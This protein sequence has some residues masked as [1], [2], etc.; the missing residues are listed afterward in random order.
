MNELIN[1]DKPADNKAQDRFQRYEFSKR[2][3][4]IISIPKNDKSLIV[5]LYGKWG[6]GKSTIL[7]FIQ[8]ELPADTVI[9]NFNPWL[10]SDEKHLLNSFFASFAVA[11]KKSEKSGKEKI[12]SFLSD[13]ADAIG[14]ITQFVGASTDGLG[15]L[16]DKLKS[17]AVETV[18]ERIDKYIVESDKN[19]VV[20]IDDIDRLDVD[21]VQYIFKVVKLVG[22]FPRTSYVLAFDD[23]MVSKALAPKYSGSSSNNTGYQFLEKII[24]IPLKIPK[25]SKKA[26]R[27]Y[28]LELIDDVINST[29]IELSK[30]DLGD[31][32]GNFDTAFLPYIDNPRLGVRYAN[33]LAFSIPLLKKEVNMA[34]LMVIE[35][36]KIFYPELYDMIRV[37]PEWFSYHSSN[38]STYSREDQ[39]KEDIKKEI[40]SAISIYDVKKQKIIIQLLQNLFPQLDAV[41]R[42]SYYSDDTYKKWLREKKI[43]SGKYFGRYFS[44]SV[45][46]NDISDSFFDQFLIDLNSSDIDNTLEN[47]KRSLELY[48]PE[49]LILRLRMWESELNLQ[50]S[51][52]LSLILSHI[53]DTFS[54]EDDFHFATTFSQ[55]ASLIARL[56]QNIP[57]NELLSFTLDILSK[58]KTLE[59]AMEIDYWLM[60][61]DE[62]NPEKAIFNKKQELIIQDKLIEKFKEDLTMSNFFTL[63]P[64]NELNRILGWWKKSSKYK[65]FDKFIKEHLICNKEQVL[66]LLKTF[67]STIKSKTLGA[68]ESVSYKSGFYQANYDRIK[69]TIDVKLLNK[70]LIKNYGSIKLDKDPSTISNRDPLDDNAIISIFQHFFRQDSTLNVKS[71]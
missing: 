69:A 50:Q 70:A 47:F 16:G 11:L 14:A 59:Y 48:S 42:N 61:R 36:L 1:A 33:T 25:A 57:T 7:N 56:I 27:L 2:I 63:L 49:D 24:Q 53:G 37:S 29:G 4:S 44:Y 9:I 45:Q 20:L 3:A 67:V 40:D 46:D 26:L 51:K 22:D 19:I 28:T 6:E 5:G 31:F 10:F 54:K 18:K 65:D 52:N 60:Y 21:E 8:N 41:Y 58:A 34:D 38:I 23:E 13:Y 43:S 15:K 71:K 32:V 64:D 12:G 39:K 55:S 17:V 62:K 30:S 66:K 68:R 35:G